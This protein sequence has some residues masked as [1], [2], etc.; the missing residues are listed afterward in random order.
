MFIFLPNLLD[1]L[2]LKTRTAQFMAKN[3]SHTVGLRTCYHNGEKPIKKWG[4]PKTHI[5]VKEISNEC[6]KMF[7][8]IR[9]QS[10]EERQYAQILPDHSLDEH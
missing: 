10:A 6:L 9:L 2:I 1:K 3:E 4:H 5:P 8:T 7:S